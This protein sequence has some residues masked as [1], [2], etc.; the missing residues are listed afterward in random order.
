MGSSL[1]ETMRLIGNSTSMAIVSIGFAIYLGGTNITPDRYPTFLLSMKQVLAAFVVLSLV[2]LI[3][4]RMAYKVRPN[5]R[6][7]DL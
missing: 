7:E 1:A 4:I 2:S 5:K 3:A 6:S